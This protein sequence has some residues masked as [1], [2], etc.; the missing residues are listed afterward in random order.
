MNEPG[1]VLDEVGTELAACSGKGV[2]SVEVE[3]LRQLSNNSNRKMPNQFLVGIQ[4]A[5]WGRDAHG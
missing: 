3:V 1:A 4:G 5:A 2:E